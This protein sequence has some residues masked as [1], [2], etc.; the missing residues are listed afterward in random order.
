MTVCTFGALV[1]MGKVRRTNTRQRYRFSI[2]H[3]KALF[4]AA[5][6]PKRF[7]EIP[8][9]HVDAYKE[10]APAYAN[11]IKRFV[12]DFIETAKNKYN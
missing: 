9:G 8:G 3:G 2:R 11:E 12:N 5:S 1:N 7:L 10:S 4:S 6:S